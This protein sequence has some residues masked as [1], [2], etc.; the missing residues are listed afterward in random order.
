MASASQPI[1]EVMTPV[2]AVV[3][4][5]TPLL[6]ARKLLR[7]IDVRHVPVLDKDRFVG[8]VSEREL[9]VLEACQGVDLALLSVSDAMTDKPYT[10][11][12][13]TPL[14]EVCKTMAANK[15]GSAIVAVGQEVQGIFTTTDALEL[16]AQVL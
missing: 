4:M 5:A 15:Y 1:S 11:T 12:P 10:V 16:L 3:D 13:D 9:A 14:G 8:V 6:D 2:V 7:D